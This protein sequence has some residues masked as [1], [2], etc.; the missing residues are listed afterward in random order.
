MSKKNQHNPDYAKNKTADVIKHGSGDAVPSKQWQNNRNLTPAGSDRP[1]E[2][3]L[4][5][6]G[7]DRPTPHVKTNECD[8]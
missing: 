4:P 3:F 1:S 7:K 6:A 5:R 8:H 2:V